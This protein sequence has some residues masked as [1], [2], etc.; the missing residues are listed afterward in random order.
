MSRRIP[1]AAR[2]FLPSL[3]A[4]LGAAACSD[5]E[6][7][8][9]P[10]GG[11]E[12][13]EAC[14]TLDAAT[15]ASVTIG[16][17]EKAF[18]T[19]FRALGPVDASVVLARVLSLGDE[20][21]LTPS[22]DGLKWLDEDV[23]PMLRDRVFVSGN[24]ES[25]ERGEVVFLL[26]PDVVCQDSTGDA[27][28]GGGVTDS[29]S[30]GDEER[31]RE[32]YTKTPL[33]VVVSRVACGAEDNVHL[34]LLA[35]T[36]RKEYVNLDLIGSKVVVR[37]D[38]GELAANT[39]IRRG[40]DA[41]PEP[42]FDQGATGHLEMVE[43]LL[44]ENKIH[45]TLRVTED[46]AVDSTVEQDGGASARGGVRI[47]ATTGDAIDITADGTIRKIEFTLALGRIQ[48]MMPFSSFIHL[49]NREAAP[50]A[51]PAEIVELSV[52]GVHG[53]FSFD[54]KGDELRGADVGIGDATR[55]AHGAR[56]IL[57]WEVNPAAEHRV[58]FT[59][60]GQSDGSVAVS[61]PGGFDLRIHYALAPVA[62]WIED[63]WAF[64]LDDDVRLTLS[65]S[66]A[67]S[68]LLRQG[69]SDALNLLR[70][71]LGSLLEVQS[72]TFEGTSRIAP[73]ESVSVP[74][75][76]CLN[77]HITDEGTHGLLQHLSSGPC[78]PPAAE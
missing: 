32:Q 3:A 75:G 29:S 74:A 11:T 40:E 8:A 28:T 44:S 20:K 73:D 76:Q 6:Q 60:T 45:A 39:T 46:I 58:N 10:L 53:R 25:E 61:V 51:S 65:G 50:Q 36:E 13:P 62:A 59:A 47:P 63:P 43:E 15:A 54:G 19:T 49:F 68:A 72:G 70:E 33:R 9:A 48:W 14:G 78:E 38:V 16:K 67:P 57:S 1:L 5:G 35:G 56:T 12:I 7:P 17:L 26:R 37:A 22:A 18:R 42:L 66:T 69:P 30:P 41:E 21:A 4:I 2:V 55:F 23:L 77:R 34:A 27:G 64:S 71:Q 52:P 31:C 24:V